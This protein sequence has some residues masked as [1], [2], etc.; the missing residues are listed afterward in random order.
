[1]KKSVNWAL[2]NIGKRNLKLN[3]K[4]IEQAKKIHSIDSSSAKWIATDALRELQSEKVRNRIHRNP[5]K[6]TSEI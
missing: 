4:A 3:E 6:K 1:M 5:S 2:R